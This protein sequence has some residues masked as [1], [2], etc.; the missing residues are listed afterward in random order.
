MQD[1]LDTISIKV[2]QNITYDEQVYWPKTLRRK[3]ERHEIDLQRRTLC[4]EARPE[5]MY[6]AVDDIHPKISDACWCGVRCKYCPHV[7]EVATRHVDDCLDT[8][9]GEQVWQSYAHSHGLLRGAAWST[10]GHTT[11]SQPIERLVLHLAQVTVV[12]A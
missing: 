1:S 5:L 9:K 4:R 11:F 3:V 6:E 2:E 7:V 10:E 8:Q 12:A